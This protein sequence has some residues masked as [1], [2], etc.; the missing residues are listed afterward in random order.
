MDTGIIQQDLNGS[1][2]NQDVAVKTEFKSD[3]QEHF[4]SLQTQIMDTSSISSNTVDTVLQQQLQQQQ[5]QLQQQ[6]DQQNQND[7]ANAFQGNYLIF[8]SLLFFE[9]SNTF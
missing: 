5:V 2:N 8:I 6:F 9:Q 4:Q 7:N 1:A 3:Q